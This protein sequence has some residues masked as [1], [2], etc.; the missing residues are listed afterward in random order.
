ME[1]PLPT[2]VPPQLPE[3]HCT[4]APVPKAPPTADKVVAVPA[5]TVVVPEID[6]GATED[7]LTVTVTEAHA[8]VLHVPEYLAK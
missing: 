4:T 6:V 7:E 1:A 2:N 3:Y 8:V 5:Q